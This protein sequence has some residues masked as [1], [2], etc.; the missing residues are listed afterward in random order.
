MATIFSYFCEETD[1]W[2]LGG[3]EGLLFL[4]GSVFIDL[5]VYSKFLP[6]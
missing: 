2:L 5:F 4:T 6:Q 3:A 1:L